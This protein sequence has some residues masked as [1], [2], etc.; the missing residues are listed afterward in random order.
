M[1]ILRTGRKSPPIWRGGANADRG[2]TVQFSAEVKAGEGTR[3][4]VEW[5]VSGG[6]PGTRITSGGRLTISDVETAEKVTVKA[7][8]LHHSAKETAMKVQNLRLLHSQFK[9]IINTL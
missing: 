6:L 1:R 9:Q 5:S 3:Q 2:D 8:S 7:K 4:G